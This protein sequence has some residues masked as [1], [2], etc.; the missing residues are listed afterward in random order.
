MTILSGRA[1]E[2]WQTPQRGVLGALMEVKTGGAVSTRRCLE[3]VGAEEAADFLLNWLQQR[4][5][6]AD[7]TKEE[8]R[9]F[10]TKS[11]LNLPSRSSRAA[12]RKS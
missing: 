9:H 12:G 3:P 11:G 8:K 2:T 5:C 10:N 1:A 6:G 4:T 7:L